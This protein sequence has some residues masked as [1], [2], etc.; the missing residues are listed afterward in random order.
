MTTLHYLGVPRI[1]PARELKWTIER[2]WQGQVSHDDLNA[3][4][5]ILRRAQWERQR[6]S[7]ADLISVGDFAWYDHILEQSLLFGVVPRRFRDTL[8]PRTADQAFTLARGQADPTHGDRPASPMRKW[9]DT[10][11]HFLEPE[12]DTTTR[13]RLASEPL[14]EQ[15]RDA[16]GVQSGVKVQFIGPA[17]YLWIS[18]FEGIDEDEALERLIPVYQQL[19]DELAG[20]NVPWVQLDEP[21][22]C[23][24]L[25]AVWRSR[26]ERA[27]SRLAAS[28]CN[29]LLATYFGGLEDNLS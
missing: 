18:R 6:D 7:G 21:V 16:Q 11:Y 20:E 13:P 12:W 1:G 25:S 8:P 29:K 2:Y 5:R 22:L 3:T 9:F 15:V 17:T 27:Y 24:D 19:L 26:V 14:L 28:P 23:L 4:A 10:N